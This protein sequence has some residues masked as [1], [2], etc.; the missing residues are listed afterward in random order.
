MAIGRALQEA[1]I[2]ACDL[3]YVNAHGTGTQTNDHVEAQALLL[4]LEAHGQQVPVSST[5]SAH[6]HALGATGALEAIATVLA[7]Q[8]QCIPPTLNVN[9]QDPAC[10]LHLVTDQAMAT[11]NLGFAL[12]NSL[13]FGGTNACLVFRHP[14][15]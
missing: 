4:A 2:D 13:A 1:S 3:G 5:K 8:D 7:I 10:V 11:N 14:E 9:D 12:S 15:S 6:G